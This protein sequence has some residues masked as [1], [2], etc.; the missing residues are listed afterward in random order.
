MGRRRPSHCRSVFFLLCIPPF[1]VGW[2]SSCHFFPFTTILMS[3]HAAI[4]IWIQVPIFWALFCLEK[5]HSMKMK[6]IL[7]F[8]ALPFQRNRHAK[9]ILPCSILPSFPQSTMT[10]KTISTW[11]QTYCSVC[12]A[13]GAINTKLINDHSN[14]QAS[15]SVCSAPAAIH[16]HY[17]AI[18]CYS[19]R[20]HFFK[21]FQRFIWLFTLSSPAIT[22]GYIF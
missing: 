7:V 8:L 21:L 15:C 19:C 12:S 10:R 9:M 6:R 17:G 20:L 4:S 14:Y 16:L 18:S 11:L 5:D 22:A 3:L 2:L 13:P 1:P